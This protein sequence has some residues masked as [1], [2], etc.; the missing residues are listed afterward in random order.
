MMIPKVYNFVNR[1]KS[2]HRD[3][4]II[5]FRIKKRKILILFHNGIL[6]EECSLGDYWGA[7]IKKV[8]K[9][10]NI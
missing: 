2:L 6:V 10:S 5:G 7:P 9:V 8:Y 1:L 3:Q 4:H